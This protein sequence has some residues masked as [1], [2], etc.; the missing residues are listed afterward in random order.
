MPALPSSRPV[1]LVVAATACWGCG[2]V[3]SKQVLDRGVPPLT[4]LAIE[5]GASCLVLAL[6]HGR[7]GPTTRSPA[8][9]RL[10]LL[11]LLNPGL[12]Y[13]LGLL[14]LLSITASMSVLLW[15]SEPLAIIVLARV[16]LGERLGAFTT[17]AVGV[18]IVGVVLVVHSPGASGSARGVV[19]SLA[20]VATCAVYS[21]LTRRFL[22][23][24][25]SLNVVL[26]QQ[27]AALGC[28]VLVTFA[29]VTTQSVELGLPKDPT[30]WALACLSGAVYYCFAFW[31]F[32]GGLRRLP[33]A[34]AGSFLP[35]IPVFGLTASHGL[36]ERLE[37][38]QWAGAAIVV[39]ATAAVA[40]RHVRRRPDVD[41]A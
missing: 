1:L 24:D 35:L 14:G 39:A 8:L 16:L 37:A 33:A 12:A 34:T 17:A 23:D 31:F 10:A 28:A 2:T 20:A 32:V 5:L 18:A 11:G 22:L 41:A 36:G 7:V 4:L 40:V 15:A 21:V 25:S 38:A 26:V 13:G 27:L 6:V 9:G 19:L 29:A 3:L 30:T